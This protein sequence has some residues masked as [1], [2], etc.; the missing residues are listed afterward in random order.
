MESLKER[1]EWYLRSMWRNNDRK[2]SEF[3]KA[4]NPWKEHQNWA[5]KTKKKKKKEIEVMHSF[6]GEHQ[7]EWK[8]ISYLDPWF[9]PWPSRKGRSILW[10]PMEKAR[11]CLS[12][13]FSENSL[14]VWRGGKRH[15]SDEEKHRELVARKP[16]LK[17]S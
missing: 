1:K 9:L 3:V 5:S 2:L 16:V 12:S 8:Y 17:N 4:W 11:S 15:L 7:L 6:L 13:V 14:Q 10:G